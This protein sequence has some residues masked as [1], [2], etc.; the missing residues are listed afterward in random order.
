MAETTETPNVLNE[1]KKVYDEL[2]N[3]HQAFT[4]REVAAEIGLHEDLYVAKGKPDLIVGLEGAF[5]ALEDEKDKLEWLEKTVTILLAK[6]VIEEDSPSETEEEEDDEEEKE[7]E[8]ELQKLQEQV[9]ALKLKKEALEQKKREK[10]A[11]KE[12][13]KLEKQEK[14][15]RESTEIKLEN[16]ENT[17]PAES[18]QKST[19]AAQLLNNSSNS[20]SSNSSDVLGLLSS[21]SILRREFV[22][23]GNIERGKLSYSGL[24]KQI[25]DG[26]AKGYSDQDIISAIQK[27]IT[28]YD[29]RTLLEISPEITL[30]ELKQMLRDYYKEQSATELYQEL[31][32]MKQG[33]NQDASDFLMKALRVRKQV[34]FASKKDGG[35]GYDSK[36]LQQLFIS[37]IESGIDREICARI[38]PYLNES[39][40]DLELMHQVSLA[41]AVRKARLEKEEENA[42][43][44]SKNRGRS[45][46]VSANVNSLTP[47]EETELVKTLKG[48]KNSVDQLSRQN[49][50]RNSRGRGQSRDDKKDGQSS[51]PRPRPQCADCKAS[52][53]RCGHCFKCKKVGHIAQD[54]TEE[55]AEPAENG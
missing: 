44:S 27:A 45:T 2:V 50:R 43:S 7:R 26:K 28:S 49:N 11:M 14:T 51:P 54:C 39:V 29:L 36:Q 15:K 25:D 19:A 3:M 37:T 47:T 18:N 48:L 32:K 41:E 23:R 10:E 30:K 17:S 21:S 31:I 42:N 24:T 40:T 16:K 5:D 13:K 9:A 34:L 52:N 6:E 53:S 20:S 35:V 12:K 38:Q 22:I 8:E 33:A 46:A 4:L 1:K 55:A